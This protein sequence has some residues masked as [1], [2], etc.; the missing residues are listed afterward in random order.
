MITKL[1]KSTKLS[2]A[3]KNKERQNAVTKLIYTFCVYS[4]PSEE[5]LERC[6]RPMLMFMMEPT[7]KV[8]RD[9]SLFTT[10]MCVRN[11]VTPIDL[12]HWYKHEIMKIIV[13][14]CAMNYCSRKFSICNS[15]KLVSFLKIHSDT[16][17]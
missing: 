16:I 8:A 2:L 5:I 12:L 13:T 9:S 7:S 11:N 10:E 4:K 17:Y 6:L 3:N 1:T 15:L 14:V